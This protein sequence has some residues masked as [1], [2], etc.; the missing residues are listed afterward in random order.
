MRTLTLTNSSS[1]HPGTPRASS[2]FQPTP[3]PSGA[4]WSGL[5][6]LLGLFLA[7]CH[8]GPTVDPRSNYFPDE[9]RTG[10]EARKAAKQAFQT[11]RER[12]EDI[13]DVSADLVRQELVGDRL[14]ESETIR[15][16]QRVK[17]HSLH[18]TWI[19]NKLNGRQVVYVDG[20]N[21][22]KMLVR[23][24]GWKGRLGIISLDP[25]GSAVKWGSRYPVTSLGYD[26]LVRRIIKNYDDAVERE[27]LGIV[28][29]GL[30]SLPD[31]QT[32]AFE[33]VLDHPDEQTGDYH[34]MRI[35]F[36]V[37]TGL[38][39][40]FMGLDKE[41]RLLED[42]F[43]QGLK[44]NQNLADHDFVIGAEGDKAPSPEPV[45]DRTS[46]TEVESR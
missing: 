46:S 31:H 27:S 37:R 29:F 4:A 25:S 14:Q 45:Q 21:D 3:V 15:W 22:G 5:C 43:W 38:P 18:L 41:G 19:G 10:P 42:Y 23:L 39:I 44:L 35:W 8:D 13:Q 24:E 9:G 32:H 40:R 36:D 7:G 6:L 20:A 11:A 28:D 1:E 34:K 16:R 33:M 17:P 2:R 30:Q 12:V 26:A